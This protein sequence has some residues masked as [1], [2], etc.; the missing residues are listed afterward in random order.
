MNI[1][2]LDFK[3]DKFDNLKTDEWNLDNIRSFDGRS[4]LK[5]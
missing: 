3:V 2:Q 4:H 5:Y 1:W